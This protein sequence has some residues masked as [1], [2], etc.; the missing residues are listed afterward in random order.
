MVFVEFHADFVGPIG[1]MYL[2]VI[3]AHP[4]W[5]VIFNMANNNTV[6]LVVPK[7]IKL[8]AHY[9]LPLHLVTDNGSQFTSRDFLKCLKL[10]V[11][12]IASRHRTTLQPSRQQKILWAF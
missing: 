8:F 9:G 11:Q 10:N 5:P 3:D 1:H 6:N 2:I 12:D 7:F 4:K